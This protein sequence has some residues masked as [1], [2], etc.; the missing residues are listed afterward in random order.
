[1]L[2]LTREVDLV[3]SWNP[4]I[5]DMRELLALSASELLVYLLL[6]CP[7]PLPQPEIVAE[8]IGADLLDS[9][10]GCVVIAT[11]SCDPQ[12]LQV[13]CWLSGG[14]V[15]WVAWYSVLYKLL[16][17]IAL[18]LWLLCTYRCTY[19]YGTTAPPPKRT[20]TQTCIYIYIYTHTTLHT[21]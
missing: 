4:A 11:H 5:A 19:G 1:M 2:C 21:L 14:G 20:Q 9:S 10:H 3:T 18:N 7:W 15:H 6:W 17:L 8:A 13:C 12:L 16:Y